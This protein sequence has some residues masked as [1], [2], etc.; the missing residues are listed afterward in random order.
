MYLLRTKYA[1]FQAQIQNKLKYFLKY[2]LCRIAIPRKFSSLF[3]S[4]GLMLLQLQELCSRKIFPIYILH[5][6]TRPF[7]NLPFLH[8]S[9]FTWLMFV[10]KLFLKRKRFRNVR[11]YINSKGKNLNCLNV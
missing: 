5:T 3:F 2:F 4:S 7:N 8:S 10:E 1:K 6:F 11:F 9:Q